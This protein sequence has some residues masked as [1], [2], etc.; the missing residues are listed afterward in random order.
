MNAGRMRERISI[1]APIKTTDEFHEPVVSYTLLRK[2]WA[3]R[4]EGTAKEFLSSGSVQS[5][6]GTVFTTRYVSGITS[7][8]RVYFGDREYDIVGVVQIDNKRRFLQ[9]RCIERVT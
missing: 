9:L 6:L 1:Y 2:L 4:A 8:H 7:E 5:E 3:H